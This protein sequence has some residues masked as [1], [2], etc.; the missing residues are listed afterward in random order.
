[1]RVLTSLFAGG[2]DA[3]RVRVAP[4]AYVL[5]KTLREL[6]ISPDFVIAAIRRGEEVWVPKADDAIQQGDIVLVI[7]RRGM[8]KQ[9]KQILR[10]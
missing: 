1:V 4:E 8:E 2:I 3:Y 9:L 10:T 5:G 7:G 6:K